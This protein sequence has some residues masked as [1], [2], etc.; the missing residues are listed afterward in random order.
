MEDGLDSGLDRD[1]TTPGLR[2]LMIVDRYKSSHA[3]DIEVLLFC[4][5]QVG[6]SHLAQDLGLQC[7][8]RP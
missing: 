5:E 1:A 8:E 2:T 6:R 7:P 4:L 3:L